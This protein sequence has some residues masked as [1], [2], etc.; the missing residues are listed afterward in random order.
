MGAPHLA[1]RIFDYLDRH[2]AWIED[3][4]ARLSRIEEDLAEEDFERMV[5]EQQENEAQLHH[6]QR[7]YRGLYHEWQRAQDLSGEE[8][9]RIKERAHANQEHAAQAILQYKRCIEH[10]ASVKR[11][12]KQAINAL[13]RGKGLISKYRTHWPD[14]PG[15]IDKKS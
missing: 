12:K 6:F 5:R 2:A 13:R 1:K 3:T 15:Y 8:R 7:E 9:A 4:I 11:E 14:E 10:I